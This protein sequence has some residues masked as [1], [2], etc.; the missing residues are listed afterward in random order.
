MNPQIARSIR[1]RSA[2]HILDHSG[3]IP[4][5]AAIY[6]L[7]D[8][9]DMQCVRYV[10]QTACPRRRYLQHLNTAKLW[11]PDELP[12]WIKSPK[13]RPLHGWIRDLYCEQ[14]RLPV[15]VVIAWTQARQARAE[16]RNRILEYLGHQ[17][18]LLN[19]ESEML[20]KQPLLI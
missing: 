16:E 5:D 17:L 3:V 11:L 15:M 1:A 8:P 18:P 4:D 13:L 20:R 2:S 9:R 7:A 10:G 6:T 12:W 14:S 19:W